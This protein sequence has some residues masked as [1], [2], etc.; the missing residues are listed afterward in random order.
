[1]T[2]HYSLRELGV[3]TLDLGKRGE[4][5]VTQIEIDVSEWMRQYPYA[6]VSM[7]ISQPDTD[8]Y[9]AAVE[10][11]NGILL[12]DVLDENTAVPGFGEAELVLTGR[13]GERL[14]SA[15]AQIFV[16]DSFSEDTPGDAP[17]HMQTWLDKMAEHAATVTGGVEEAEEYVK[18]VEDAADA[19][20]A[21]Y[22][23]DTQKVL[24][25]NDEAFFTAR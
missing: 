1:M 18:R 3:K 15:T 16:E 6:G 17:E 2:K 7:Y 24:Y 5:K 14:K 9:L 20:T 8:V 11:K 10:T 12:W 22:P 21:V 23:D 25:V 13:K 19:V 4:N